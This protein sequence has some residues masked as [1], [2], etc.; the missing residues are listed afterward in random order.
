M[1]GMGVSPVADGRAKESPS[2]GEGAKLTTSFRLSDEALRLLAR[3]SERSGIT[4]TAVFEL[5]IREKA[6]REGVS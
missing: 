3:M 4:K 6:K 1:D 2:G 5:A